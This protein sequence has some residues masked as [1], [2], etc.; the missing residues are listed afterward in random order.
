MM[1]LVVEG[2]A[3]T[4]NTWSRRKAMSRIMVPDAQRSEY[5]CLGVWKAAK[6]QDG[7]AEG[8]WST[9]VDGAYQ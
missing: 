7:D 2:L 8:A 6:P 3:A 9:G 5:R 1:T 4:N